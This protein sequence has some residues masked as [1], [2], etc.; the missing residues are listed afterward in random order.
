[1]SKHVITQGQRLNS[2][3]YN[4]CIINMASGLHLEQG[5]SLTVK[6]IPTDQN[7]TSKVFS[8]TKGEMFLHWGHQYVP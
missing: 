8:K 6:I 2:L 5:S 1:M 3:V 7:T 4:V